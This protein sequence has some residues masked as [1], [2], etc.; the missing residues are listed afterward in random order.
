M[1]MFIEFRCSSERILP[2]IIQ[3][4]RSRIHEDY[5]RAMWDGGTIQPQGL[6]FQD[7]LRM[8]VD[9]EL[10]CQLLFRQSEKGR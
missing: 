4:E 8:K 6:I 3:R 2:P 1:F 10:I 7:A 5:K 9:M